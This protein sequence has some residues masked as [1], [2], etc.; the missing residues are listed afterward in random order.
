[1]SNTKPKS[2]S[3]SLL[4]GILPGLIGFLGIGHFYAGRIRRGL[5]LLIG[6]WVLAGVSLFCFIAA[7]MSTLV[8]P[9]SGQP[10]EELPAYF[11]IFCSISIILSL[12][13]L[14]LWIWQIINARTVCRQYNNQIIEPTP[15]PS[16]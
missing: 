6:G 1:M 7:S 4:L 15:T 13:G 2:E 3:I 5:I 9:P 16:K 12:G 8:I 11:F 14:A 10:P